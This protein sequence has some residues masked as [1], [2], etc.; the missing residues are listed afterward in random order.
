MWKSF[1]DKRDKYFW[2]QGKLSEIAVNLATQD[3]V[4]CLIRFSNAI[5]EKN[6]FE[7]SARDFLPR[8]CNLFWDTTTTSVFRGPRLRK[9]WAN[10]FLRFFNAVGHCFRRSA[11]R[12][13]FLLISFQRLFPLRII[14]DFRV[15]D[16]RWRE[17]WRSWKRKSDFNGGTSRVRSSMTVSLRVSH[18]IWKLNEP[19]EYG[20][21]YSEL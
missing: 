15:R 10:I 14:M 8:I 18:D 19:W 5:W 13:I 16:Y 9:V 6:E 11:L 4:S 21:G 7:N 3:N 20:N 12:N 17:K 1:A 2:D